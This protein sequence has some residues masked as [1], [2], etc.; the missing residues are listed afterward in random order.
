MVVVVVLVV[1][2]VLL[3]VVVV[4]VVVVATQLAAR[5][6][7]G[8]IRP[9]EAWAPAAPLEG[10]AH[11]HAGG[12]TALELLESPDMATVLPAVEG[13]QRMPPQRQSLGRMAHR[14]SPAS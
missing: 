4:V 12:T 11:H 8:D 1:L 10:A 7:M 5:A 13:R 2:V 14:G 3:L 6:K 9:R